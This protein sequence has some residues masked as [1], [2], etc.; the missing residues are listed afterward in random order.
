[1]L[2]ILNSKGWIEFENVSC[3]DELISIAQVYGQLKI[4]TNNNVIQILKPKDGLQA[5]KGTFSNLYGFGVFPYHT[6]VAFWAKPAHFM[7]LSSTNANQCNTL[8]VSLTDIWDVLSEKDKQYFEK[9]IFVVKTIH[10]SFYS[11]LIFK[12]YGNICI[13]YDPSCM[14]PINESAKRVIPILKNIFSEI[15]THQIKWTGNKA[16]I[17]N[18]WRTLHGRSSA[19]NDLTRN[20]KRIYII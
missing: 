4:H 17:I 19:E 2:E 12:E 8:V 6:D 14:I 18:N 15:Q 7:L 20:L 16:V 5:I 10:S 1:M 9:A 11:T 3:D 13:R